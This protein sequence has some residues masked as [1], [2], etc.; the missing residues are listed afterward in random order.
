MP[1]NVQIAK[2]DYYLFSSRDASANDSVIK[3]YTANGYT[4]AIFFDDSG[5]PLKPATKSFSGTYSL[6][7]RRSSLPDVIDMLRHEGPV[8]VYYDGATNSM[9]TTAQEPVGEAES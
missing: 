8:Y 5:G 4:G 1:D 2:Y 3:L 7:Y 6:Y 9:L